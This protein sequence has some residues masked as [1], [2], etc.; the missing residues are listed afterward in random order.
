MD[1][2][3]GGWCRTPG[4]GAACTCCPQRAYSLGN[5]KATAPPAGSISPSPGPIAHA[6]V[7]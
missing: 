4:A 1:A 3:P 6:I 5:T 2:T 7:W